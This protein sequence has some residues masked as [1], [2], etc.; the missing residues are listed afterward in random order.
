LAAD[1][2]AIDVEFQV[3]TFVLPKP[4]VQ[5]GYRI[6]HPSPRCSSAI[7]HDAR[8]TPHAKRP[9]SGF[10]Q[11]AFWEVRLWACRPPGWTLLSLAL[12][13]SPQRSG[14]LSVTVQPMFS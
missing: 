7:L 1:A 6:L 11:V 12:A 5:F 3:G 10:V 14:L 9:P 8:P 4:A 2:A 13:G